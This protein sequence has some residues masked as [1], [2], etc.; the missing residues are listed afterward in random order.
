MKQSRRAIGKKQAH[1]ASPI[2]DILDSEFQ[3]MALPDPSDSGEVAE[4]KEKLRSEK[5]KNDHLALKIAESTDPAQKLD[6]QKL[7]NAS[8]R[9]LQALRRARSKR[10]FFDGILEH[11]QQSGPR[12]RRSERSLSERE[13][14]IRKAIQY[15]KTGQEYATY[16]D[17]HRQNTPEKWQ[18]NKGNP[19]SKTH[20]LAYDDPHWRELMYK[21]K[22]RVAARMRG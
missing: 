17:E 14:I 13:K 22:S 4:I 18:K 19:C 10:A 5:E 9:P 12:K 1:T 6:L 15:N 7:K 3:H 11:S 21:E 16:L 20:A 8:D 2:E